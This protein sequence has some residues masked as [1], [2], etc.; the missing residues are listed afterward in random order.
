VLNQKKRNR[1]LL[2]P[3]LLSKSKATRCFGATAKYDAARAPFGTLRWKVSGPG[4]EEDGDGAVPTPGM[5]NLLTIQV[6]KEASTVPWYDCG[7]QFH[8]YLTLDTVNKTESAQVIAADVYAHFDGTYRAA[9]PLTLG[10]DE[11]FMPGTYYLHVLHDFGRF[12]GYM[13][14][15]SHKARMLGGLHVAGTPRVLHIGT[16]APDVNTYV[17]AEQA[18]ALEQDVDRDAGGTLEQCCA[19]VWT[20]RGCSST[21]SALG[22]SADARYECLKR[23]TSKAT[24]QAPPAGSLCCDGIQRGAWRNGVWRG[25]DCNIQYFTT[26]A[27]KRCA[28][29]RH[30]HLMTIGDSVSHSMKVGFRNLFDTADGTSHTYSEQWGAMPLTCGAW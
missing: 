29:E 8:V 28:A 13:T 21:R 9:F 15:D 12:Q 2:F 5:S 16:P 26:E 6:D 23:R 1:E 27:W 18:A 22:F 4:I 25:R 3:D 17:D 19:G 10:A 14:M 30:V 24:L 11:S 7:D 20:P